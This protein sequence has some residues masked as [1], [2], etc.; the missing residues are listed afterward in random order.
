MTNALIAAL[1]RAIYFSAAASSAAALSAAALSGAEALSTCVVAVRD[2]VARELIRPPAHIP[3]TENYLMISQKMPA[4]ATN[5]KVNSTV[6][7]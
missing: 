6:R 4:S 1:M 3:T 2:H 7:R 5:A